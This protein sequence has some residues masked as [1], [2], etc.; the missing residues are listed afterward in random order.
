MALK[1]SKQHIPA[2]PKEIVLEMRK[3]YFTNH[4]SYTTIFETYKEQYNKGVIRKAVMGIGK[5]YAGIEDDIPDIKKEKRRPSREIHNPRVL[6]A[7]YD[8]MQWLG[9]KRVPRANSYMDK[10]TPQQIMDYKANEEIRLAKIK[11]EAG[12]D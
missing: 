1:P 8:T 12:W 11:K 10:W 9:N 7:K 5:Y 2:I 4:D 6:R 3:A